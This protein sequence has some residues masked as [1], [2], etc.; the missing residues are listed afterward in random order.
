M[1]ES[2]LASRWNIL[3]WQCACLCVNAGNYVKDIEGDE[4]GE[5][6]EVETVEEKTTKRA[7]PNYGKIAKAIADAQH[8]GVVIELPSINEAQVDFVPDI[9]NN[10]IAYSLQSINVVSQ[11]LQDAILSQRPFT[12]IEDFIERVQPTIVQMTGLIKSGCFDRLC[13]KDRRA[14]MGDYLRLLAQKECPPKDKLTTVQLKKALELNISLP[15]FTTEIRL[16]KYKKYIDVK[17]ADKV[18]KRYILTEPG[19]I[20]FFKDYLESDFNLS[21]GEYDYLPEGKVMVKESAFKRVF[22]KKISAIMDYLNT[23]EGKAAYQNLVQSDYINGIKEK[24]CQGTLSA[25]EM[26]TMSFYFSGHELKN[27]NYGQYGCKSFFSL[28]EYSTSA[29]MCAIAGTVTDYNNT[30]H[31]VSLLTPEGIVDVKFF[32]DVYA[33]YN[34]KISV[35]DKKTN[36][37]TVIEDSWFKRGTKIIVYGLRK[38]NMFHCRS[39]RFSTDYGTRV[40]MVGLIDKIYDSGLADIKFQ[41]AQAS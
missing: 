24:Y 1:Q 27:L 16:F 21:K 7:A 3:Y 35:I 26:E 18:N 38:E 8:E 11:D 23:D 14:I 33:R 31:I 9:E 5:P 32:K 4:E 2:N 36:K 41:R 37:K 20:K 30:K 12:S 15:G 22:D 10:S 28:P 40:R 39:F 17:Q 25:W 34:R 19:C 29:D 13:K 6:E